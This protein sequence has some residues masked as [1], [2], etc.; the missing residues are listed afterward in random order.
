MS[1]V[2]INY[3]R[4]DSAG[5]AGRLMDRLAAHFGHKK[6]FMDVTDI[7]PGLDF[8]QAIA[9]GIGA[10][11]ALLVVMSKQW[12]TA[13]AADGTRRLDDP[14]DHLRLEIMAALERGVRVIPLLVRGARMPA[15]EQ[16]PTA[17]T[18]LARKQAIELSDERWDFDVGRL[19]GVLEKILGKPARRAQSNPEARKPAGKSAVRLVAA[20]VLLSSAAL[21][22][23]GVSLGEAEFTDSLYVS[24]QPDLFEQGQS[25]NI[26]RNTSITHASPNAGTSAGLAGTW[27]NDVG[28]RYEITQYGETLQSQAYDVYGNLIATGSGSADDSQLQLAYTYQIGGGGLLNGELQPDGR[29]IDFSYAD[30]V[31]GMTVTGQLHLNHYAGQQ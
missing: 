25:L 27:Y 8:V 2:F 31:S 20:T 5:Y 14:N 30:Y 29:H 1:G 9:D 15:E 16:L 13:R 26:A 22:G 3:R 24:T 28:V 10:C 23:L 18:A 12:L 7:E 21:I 11:D 17:L 6:V 4:D 19:V